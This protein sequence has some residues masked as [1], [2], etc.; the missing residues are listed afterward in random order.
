MAYI[1]HFSDSFQRSGLVSGQIKVGLIGFG[2]SGKA[3]G[4]LSCAMQIFGSE[5]TFA[6]S[7]HTCILSSA[8][9]ISVASFAACVDPP[10][11]NALSASRSVFTSPNESSL[12]V[13]VCLSAFCTSFIP[14][15]EMLTHGDKRIP[16]KSSAAPG[17]TNIPR[18]KTR[19][20]LPVQ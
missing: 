4:E 16:E 2:K 7:H 11:A 5:S 6:T 20:L 13:K 19:I 8:V 18:G 12:A 17:H 14:P 9:S 1:S 15:D 10:L 3:V